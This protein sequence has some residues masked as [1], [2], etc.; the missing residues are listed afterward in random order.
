MDLSTVRPIFSGLIGAAL[1]VWF[2]RKIAKWM[3]TTCAG[4]SIASVAHKHRWKI[5]VANALGFAA[6]LGGIS[7]YKFGIFAT[8]DWHGLGLAFGAACVLPTLLLVGLSLFEGPQSVREA[9]VAYAVGQD[10]PPV[11]LN[12]ILA[13]GAVLFFVTLASL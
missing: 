1:A 12:S 5:R 7:L 8:N 10:T 6:F 3:P 11:L 2:L 4:Q 13:A 9:L